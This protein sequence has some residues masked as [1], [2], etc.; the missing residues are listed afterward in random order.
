M[1]VI[2]VVMEYA[3]LHNIKEVTSP[4]SVPAGHKWS[5]LGSGMSNRAEASQS[6]GI[7]IL[8]LQSYCA[9]QYVHVCDQDVE[10]GAVKVYC[11]ASMLFDAV[12]V[13]PVPLM[14][15]VLQV[16]AQLLGADPFAKNADGR[17]AKV[18][19]TCTLLSGKVVFQDNFKDVALKTLHL[20]Q[21]V[22]AQLIADGTGSCNTD[23]HLVMMDGDK[24]LRGNAFVWFGS[25]KQLSSS[26]SSSVTRGRKA[27]AK[28]APMKQSKLSKF[29]AT[30]KKADV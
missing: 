21:K 26:S 25:A 7:N 29:W 9:H 17:V 16:Q 20:K 13:R 28:K 24:P 27:C 30:V 8:G 15:A 4:V 18:L 14:N 12:I 10:T 1:I 22:R 2:M 5:R 6:I 19:V 23:F 11:H 3:R